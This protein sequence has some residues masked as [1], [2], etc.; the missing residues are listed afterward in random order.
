MSHYPL[1]RKSDAH[2]QEPDGAPPED[3]GDMFREGWDC[4]TRAASSLLLALATQLLVCVLLTLGLGSL[5]TAAPPR[6][7]LLGPAAWRL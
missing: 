1:Y 2:C 7:L 4:L 5:L 6:R 3:K